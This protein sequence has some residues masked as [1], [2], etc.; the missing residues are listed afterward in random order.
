MYGSRK[1]YAMKLR[2]ST[3]NA[4]IMHERFNIDLENNPDFKM[5]PVCL[6][7]HIRTI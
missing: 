1:S 3:I 2:C 5:V 6:L 4:M 7:G